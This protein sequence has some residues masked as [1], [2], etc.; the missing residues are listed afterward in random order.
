MLEVRDVSF[1]YGQ[2]VVLRGIS[3]KIRRGEF[4]GIIGPNG[5]GKTTLLR[6]ISGLLRPKEGEIF[7]E[8][9]RIEWIPAHHVV[10]LGLVQVPEGRHI[11]PGM[12]VQ[13]NL[14]L[15][16]YAS[17][18]ASLSDRLE[19]V[20]ELFPVLARRRRQ[21][22]GTLSGGEQQMLAIGRALMASPRL[23]LL[24]EPTL[25]LS[26]LMSEAIFGTLTYLHRES[27]LTIGLVSQ[28]VV[29]TLEVTQRC[30]VL[31]N[32][33]CVE[34]GDSGTLMNSSRI[35]EAYLGIS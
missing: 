25:G 29:S 18:R 5:A 24:D 8:G 7:F 30:Y 16:W 15:G 1:A 14:E 31:E 17:P 34:E 19:Q 28:E 9:K 22:A 2:A 32:G 3:L 26:P 20:L 6:L 13:E 4:V 10:R 11:F 23:L 35:T 27:G 21:L 12:T 33:S